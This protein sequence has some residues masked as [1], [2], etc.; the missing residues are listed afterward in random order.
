[1]YNY[2]TS[3]P[4]RVSPRVFNAYM[5]DE[6]CKQSPTQGDTY[7]AYA[8][9]ESPT[10]NND[11]PPSGAPVINDLRCAVGW[12]FMKGVIVGCPPPL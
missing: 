9:H 7:A 3:V 5:W 6:T 1:M 2:R 12:S 10:L 8:G 11:P 4:A